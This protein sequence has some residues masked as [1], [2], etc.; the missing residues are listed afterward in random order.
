MRKGNESI[1]RNEEENYEIVHYKYYFLTKTE[2]KDY[3]LKDNEKFLAGFV[4]ANETYAYSMLIETIRAIEVNHIYDT[5]EY[6]VFIK[7]LQ[8]TQY[9]FGYNSE[10]YNNW[11]NYVNKMPYDKAR[12]LIKLLN[13]FYIAGKENIR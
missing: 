4:N 11:I 13:E 12:V 2:M 7:N 8:R 1:I 5:D 10:W 3:K 6:K 9:S